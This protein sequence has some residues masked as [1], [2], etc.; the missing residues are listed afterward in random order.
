MYSRDIAQQT[1]LTPSQIMQAKKFCGH[2]STANLL[3]ILEIIRDVEK[4][5]KT[6]TIDMDIAVDYLLV[7]IL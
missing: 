2:Y 4:G 1:T 7:H 3:Y 5:I 6:G